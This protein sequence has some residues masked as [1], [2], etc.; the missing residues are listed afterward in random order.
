MHGIRTDY[1][2]YKTWYGLIKFV[3]K[4]EEITFIT[5]ISS[6]YVDFY[7]KTALFRVLEI[8]LKDTYNKIVAILD[9]KGN[10]L[11][12]SDCVDCRSV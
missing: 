12:E 3:F 2:Y 9:E 5:C 6:P 1:F 10:F 8:D 11:N 4:G 7:A